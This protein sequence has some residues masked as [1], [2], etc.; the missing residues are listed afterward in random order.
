MQWKPQAECLIETQGKQCWCNSCDKKRF[1]CLVKQGKP[2]YRLINTHTIWK[3]MVV[4]IGKSRLKLGKIIIYQITMLPLCPPVFS[5]YNV[6]MLLFL[7]F[8]F[9]K[10]KKKIC[11]LFFC[12]KYIYIYIFLHI[13]S[14]RPNRPTFYHYKCIQI[15]S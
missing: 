2:I 14:L 11:W 9:L 12:W 15:Y 10:K 8:F 5:L 4:V 3:Y 13:F 6:S 7:F 1:K